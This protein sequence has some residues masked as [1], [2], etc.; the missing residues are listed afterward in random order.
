[1]GECMKQPLAVYLCWH[2]DASVHAKPLAE[3]RYRQLCRDP[4]RPFSRGMQIP[5][6]YRSVPALGGELPLPIRLGDQERTAIF[7]FATD[8]MV[9]S[10]SWNAYINEVF[11]NISS[12]PEKHRVY[13]IALTR[14]ALKLSGRITETSGGLVCL[15]RRQGF[16]SGKLLLV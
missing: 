12:S 6:F 9:A 16:I 4:D 10:D 3:K 14:N 8:E 15:D 2:E 7:I 1:M 13:I 11:N 5:V